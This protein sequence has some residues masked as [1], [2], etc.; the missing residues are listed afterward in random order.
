MVNTWGPQ[1]HGESKPKKKEKYL[2]PAIQ[3]RLQNMEQHLGIDKQPV[4]EDVH[5]RI[6]T[7][8]D[9]ILYLES[10]SPEYFDGDLRFGRQKD[11]DDVMNKI[12]QRITELKRKICQ[13]K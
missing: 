13:I 8:E 9:R 6:K 11:E 3:E 12:D 10:V 7:L 5:A 2:T 1:T 4:P